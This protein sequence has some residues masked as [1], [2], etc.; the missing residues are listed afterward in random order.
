MLLRIDGK[1]GEADRILDA[2]HRVATSAKNRREN[3][4]YGLLAVQRSLNRIRNDDTSGALLILHEWNALGP[5]PPSPL[6]QTVLFR[7][8]VL[9]GRISRYQGN[10]EES[11]AHLEEASASTKLLTDL[12][13]SEDLRELTYE[14]ADALR[15]LDQ[16]KAA[17]DHLRQELERMSHATP[18]SALSGRSLLQASLAESLFAQGQTVDAERLCHQ[19]LSND[20]AMRL[21]RLRVS[22]IL[23]KIY[24][25]SGQLEASRYWSGALGVISE[26]SIN[27]GYTTLVI[28]LSML[29]IATCLGNTSIQQQTQ[30]QVANLNYFTSSMRGT[31]R[32]WIT[33]MYNWEIHLES[34]GIRS[35]I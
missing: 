14:L 7:K 12:T 21:G 31:T 17:E 30:Q 32:Y 20:K 27:H 16:P 29:E 24:H 18:G 10:F 34:R 35:H 33:G 3:A 15:E 23:A 22:I 2:V 9:L 1:L 28:L 4:R 11:L 26:F 8:K 5:D 25:T 6:E 13:F 19:V